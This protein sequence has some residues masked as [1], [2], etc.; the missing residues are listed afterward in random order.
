MSNG[1]RM[2]PP[3]R[4]LAAT[5]LIALAAVGCGTEGASPAAESPLS[6]PPIDAAV[7]AGVE[8]VADWPYRQS[9]EGD[10]SGDGST[11]RITLTSDVSLAEDGRPLW[12]DGHR[13]A[14]YVEEGADRTLLYSAFVPNGFV[15]A[16]LSPATEG[17]AAALLVSE[18][19]PQHLRILTIEYAGPGRVRAGTHAEYL[20]DSWLPGFATIP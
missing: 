10:L 20:I 15:E 3:T 6:R 12:E 9:I 4:R 5:T 2:T 19:T 17:A 7:A 8:A 1:N 18:R 16:A 13:W 11:E 14:A